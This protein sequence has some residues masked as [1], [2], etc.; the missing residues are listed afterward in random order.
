MTAAK[1]AV[2]CEGYNY[3][4]TQYS[5]EYVTPSPPLRVMS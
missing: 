4:G 2:N 1:C 3:F 5:S